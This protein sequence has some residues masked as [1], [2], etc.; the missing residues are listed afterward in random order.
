MPTTY[1]YTT[2]YTVGLSPPTPPKKQKQNKN[3]YL[4]AN[5]IH[6]RTFVVE[7]KSFMCNRNKS[8]PRIEPCG[9]P[10]FIGK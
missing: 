9:T 6:L 2:R 1:K 3:K 10:H 5:I 4:T 8:G 7:L